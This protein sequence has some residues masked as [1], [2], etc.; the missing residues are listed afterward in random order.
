MNHDDLIIYANGHA[1][2]VAAADADMSLAELLHEWRDLT[3]T[4]V[5]CGI[6]VCRACTCG[7]AQSTRRADGEVPRMRNDRKRYRGSYR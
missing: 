2:K 5:R 4:K 1:V 6:G 3:G 7:P